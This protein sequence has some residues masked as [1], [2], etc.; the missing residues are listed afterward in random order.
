MNAIRHATSPI[1]NRHGLPIRLPTPRPI[2]PVTVGP[3]FASCAFFALMTQRVPMISVRGRMYRGCGKSIG[4]ARFH[5]LNRD[6][7]LVRVPE[8]LF[9]T[10]SIYRSMPDALLAPFM[11]ELFIRYPNCSLNIRSI[12]VILCRMKAKAYPKPRCR[13]WLP[14]I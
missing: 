6:R 10:T 2:D 13:H 8:T 9:Q 7:V 1:F 3:D 11:F 14:T 5:H 4:C 12:V